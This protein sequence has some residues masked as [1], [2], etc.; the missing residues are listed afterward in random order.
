M[1]HFLTAIP[2]LCFLVCV[3]LSYSARLSA[4]SD[5][6]D[7]PIFHA[8]KT[9][10]LLSLDKKKKTLE[11]TF[12]LPKD[13]DTELQLLHNKR[14]MGQLV[15]SSLTFSDEDCAVGYR[16]ALRSIKDKSGMYYDYFK[17]EALWDSPTILTI[18]REENNQTVIT[19]NGEKVEIHTLK[20]IQYLKIISTAAPI[21]I[22]SI[23]YKE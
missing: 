22:K 1:K 9:E 21:S 20:K 15:D 4:D 6:I 14:S 18:H 2:R 5:P 16:A 17:N 8:K 13:S 19:L 3:F 7:P 10:F 23:A 11:I 12:S